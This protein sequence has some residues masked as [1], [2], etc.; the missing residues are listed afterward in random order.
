MLQID[1][2][3]N[4]YKLMF[5]QPESEQVL[6]QISKLVFERS[7]HSEKKVKKNEA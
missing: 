6:D 2:K 1:N 5:N 4:T 7:E 3:I